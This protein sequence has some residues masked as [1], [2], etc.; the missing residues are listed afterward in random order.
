M[1]KKQIMSNCISIALLI[2]LIPNI[3]FIADKMGIQLA[4]A[5]YQDIVNWVSAGGTLTTGFAIIVGVTVPAWIAEAAAAF[6]IA[7][8]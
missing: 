3:Y 8:A 7:S 6:G 2:A 5:W 1:S 4:P